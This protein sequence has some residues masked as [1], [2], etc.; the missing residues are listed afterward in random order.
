MST[1]LTLTE[2]SKVAGVQPDYLMAK[3]GTRRVHA[4]R[5]EAGE[6]L[7]EPDATLVTLNRIHLRGTVEK[8]LAELR[9]REQGQ[10]A[11]PLEDDP[12]TPMEAHQ[13]SPRAQRWARSLG[14]PE[15]KLRAR[16]NRGG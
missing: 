15:D 4:T 14:V 13:L 2:M 5:T 11:A 6:Y 7:F 12:A 16:L 1:L 3:V 8:T 10:L 9:G